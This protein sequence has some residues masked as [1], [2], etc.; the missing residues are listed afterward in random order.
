MPSLIC[1]TRSMGPARSSRKRNRPGGPTRELGHR[2]DLRGPALR[3]PADVDPLLFSGIV[4]RGSG[5]QWGSADRVPMLMSASPVRGR[6]RF[7]VGRPQR[8]VGGHR[9]RSPNSAAITLAALAALARISRAR[10]VRRTSCWLNNCGEAAR[11]GG[12]ARQHPRF[13]NCGEAALA[14]LAR[15]SRAREVRRTSCWLNNCG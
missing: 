6:R 9:Q 13:N 7:D 2:L 14:A 8:G 10:E 15:I 1:S 11:A 5:G 12:G 4:V 3:L